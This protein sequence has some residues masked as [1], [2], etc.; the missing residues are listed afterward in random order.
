MTK[1][2]AIEKLNQGFAITHTLWDENE[3]GKQPVIVKS[4]N[5]SYA[6]DYRD[7]FIEPFTLDN[8]VSP[9]GWEL[10]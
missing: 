6:L 3:D 1:D 10:V 5:G 9:V 4:D 8:M 7:G 2:E